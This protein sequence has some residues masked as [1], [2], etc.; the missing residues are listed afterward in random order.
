MFI[1]LLFISLSVCSVFMS[2]CAGIIGERSVQENV[3]YSSSTP[4][5]HL[6]VKPDFSYLGKYKTASSIMK[7]NTWE[8][9]KVNAILSVYGKTIYSFKP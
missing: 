4:K 7:C 9:R 6:K 2:G 8:S 5:L 1:R 3:F